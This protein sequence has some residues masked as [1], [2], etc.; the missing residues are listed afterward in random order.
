MKTD[1]E[2][3]MRLLALIAACSAV[4]GCAHGSSEAHPASE[5]D[6][7]AQVRARLD[8]IWDSAAKRDFA[9][10]RSYHLY[11][12]K[13]TEFKDGTPRADA[14]TGE[15]REREFF[16]AVS[17][18]NVVMN[19]LAVNVFGG[20]AIATFNGDF[21]GTME[22]HP[23]A[24]KQQVTLVFAQDQGEWKIVHEHFS[25]LGPQTPQ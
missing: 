11:G 2:A 10:L 9:R 5:A 18:P 3:S 4:F 13:F 17:H 23:I 6:A 14:T 16:S 15:Q 20:V 25:P 1:T 22:G 21:S 12:P 7:Q 8:Q 19:D 24:A